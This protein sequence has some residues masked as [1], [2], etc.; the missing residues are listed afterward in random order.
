VQPS[1]AM[2]GSKISRSHLEERLILRAWED[3][4]FRLGLLQDPKGVVAREM[5]AMAGKPVELPAELQIHVH[6]E[7]PVDMH[8]I[9]PN[10]RDELAEDDL[11]L[12]VGWGKLLR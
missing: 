2:G 5:S 11:S 4:Q 7:T 10:R 1:N 9:L 12:L 3:E 6:Q 8:F